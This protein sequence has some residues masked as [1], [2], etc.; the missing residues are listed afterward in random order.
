MCTTEREVPSEVPSEVL[1]L[2]DEVG[3]SQ[4][5]RTPS[6]SATPRRTNF[7]HTRVPSARVE[8]LFSRLQVCCPSLCVVRFFMDIAKRLLYFSH[9]KQA[10]MDELTNSVRTHVR[11]HSLT[12]SLTNSRT[13]T[14]RTNS[15]THELTCALSLK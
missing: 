15:R 8:P 10:S 3:S 13:H 1:P 5:S 14:Q 12:N 11:T 7:Q 2:V 4:R 9:A 6:R